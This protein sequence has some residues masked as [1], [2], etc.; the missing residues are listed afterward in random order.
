MNCT[1]CPQEANHKYILVR[2]NAG[3]NTLPAGVKSKV[4]NALRNN[5]QCELS[6]RKSIDDPKTE[7]IIECCSNL[8]QKAEDFA[9]ENL[10]YFKIFANAQEARTYISANLANWETP[11]E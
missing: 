9:S 10:D 4:H 2:K 6:I 11:D 8:P 1:G 7:A 3:L 5:T